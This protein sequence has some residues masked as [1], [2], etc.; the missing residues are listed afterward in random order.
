MHL[1]GEVIGSLVALIKTIIGAI[2]NAN[3]NDAKANAL[4]GYSSGESNPLYN[5]GT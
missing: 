3:L 5:R 2:G 4:K 1:L